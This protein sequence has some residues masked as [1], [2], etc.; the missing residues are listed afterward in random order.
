MVRLLVYNSDNVV[1]AV[2]NQ[3]ENGFEID[4]R[5]KELSKDS[6]VSI[7]L[8]LRGENISSDTIEYY[9]KMRITPPRHYIQ[10]MIK[11]KF[12]DKEPT[13]ID[14][15]KLNSGRTMMDTDYIIVEEDG[16]KSELVTISSLTDLGELETE[17]DDIF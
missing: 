10:D 2:I 3:T 7:P 6:C 8:L 15:I 11:E 9:L 13:L 4:H 16:V 12:K 1:I 14:R 17:A 5:A